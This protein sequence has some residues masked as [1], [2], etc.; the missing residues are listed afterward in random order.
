M[1]GERGPDWL[2]IVP[3]LVAVPAFL[4]L[5]SAAHAEKPDPLDSAVL[6]LNVHD[7]R[8]SQGTGIVVDRTERLV[9]T[10]AHLLD[11]LETLV[12]LFPQFKEGQ[13]IE[14]P[15]PYYEQ[16]KK[17]HALRGRIWTI[18]PSR[19][20]AF[21]Q[22]E[23]GLE[24]KTEA[25][26]ASRNA[27]GGDA[28][29]WVGNPVAKNSMWV[30]GS[31]RVRDVTDRQWTY[32]SGQAVRTRILQVEGTEPLD[33]GF[34]GGGVYSARGECL[35]VIVAGPEPG[36]PLFYCIDAGEVR[37]FLAKAMTQQALRHFLQGQDLRA[38][39]RCERAISFN[40]QA[41]LAYTRRGSARVMMGKWDEALAD[42]DRALQV[43]PSSTAARVNRAFLL[44]LQRHFASAPDRNLMGEALRR[45]LLAW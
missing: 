11:D 35:G 43:Q 44:V 10:C 24:S 7:N 36:S 33:P 30:S 40:P 19:D 2:R 31:G 13:V 15:F 14:D 12:V 41:S 38:L 34:S 16:R 29:S 39:A 3:L 21:I 1:H 20:L 27:S 5:A 22:L 37:K 6:I 32:A 8:V 28:V 9:L 25:R 23:S 18:D 4:A 26:W 17:G 45:M 42:F